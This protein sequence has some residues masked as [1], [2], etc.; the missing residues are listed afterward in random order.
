MREGTDM[1]PRLSMAPWSDLC[2][3]ERELAVELLAEAG[4]SAARERFDTG[5]LGEPGNV[6]ES[7]RSYWRFVAEARG[8]GVTARNRVMTRQDLRPAAFCVAFE[9]ERRR[10]LGLLP[11]P[12]RVTWLT[13]AVAQMERV[14][15]AAVAVGES[16]QLVEASRRER[17]FRQGRIPP[18]PGPTEMREMRRTGDRLVLALM[19]LNLAADGQGDE[20]RRLLR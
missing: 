20:L 15:Y 7:A 13:Q 2:S 1:R 9:D 19:R 11:V 4:R 10:L 8:D 6:A 14:Y 12:Q 18:P 5:T 3:E 17:L 16:R